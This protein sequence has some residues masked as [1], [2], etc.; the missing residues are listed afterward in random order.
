MIEPQWRDAFSVT[1]PKNEDGTVYVKVEFG[2]L[3]EP[4]DDYTEQDYEQWCMLY[5]KKLDL[6]K[7]L[8]AGVP[9]ETMLEIATQLLDNERKIAVLRKFYEQ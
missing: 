7:Q 5:F 2:S 8:K 6:L 9:Y 4:F 3:I 1:F